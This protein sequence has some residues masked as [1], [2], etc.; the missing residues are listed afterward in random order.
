MPGYQPRVTTD[1]VWFNGTDVHTFSLSTGLGVRITE[2][3]GWD[4]RPDVRDVRELRFGQDGERADNLYLGGRTI[5]IS[6]QVYGSSWVDLQ[7]RKRALAAV[8][9]PSSTEVLFKVPDPATASPTG[10]YA[11]TGMTGYERVSARV[12]EPIAFGDMLGS[13][14]MTFQVSLRASDPRVYSDVETSTDS[15]TTGTA[16]R[17]VTV[18]QAGTYATPAT[19]TATGPTA[20]TATVSEPSGPLSLAW[21]GLTLA[22]GESMSFD[23]LERTATFNATFQ[24]VRLA[25]TDIAAQWMLNETS[26]T[27]ADNGEGTAAYDGTYTGGFTLN[28]AGPA[29]G[30]ASTTFNGST[31]YVTVPYNAALHP[32]ATAFECWAKT[33]AATTQ[34]ILDNDNGTA[35]WYLEFNSAGTIRFVVRTVAGTALTISS[36]VLPSS[37]WYHIVAVIDK[38]NNY[39]SLYVNGALVQRR[40]VTIDETAVTSGALQIARRDTSE[41]LTGSV[42]ACTMYETALSSS[43]VSDLYSASSATTALSG[44]GYLDAASLQWQNL[45]TASSTFTLASTGL[46]T[47]S[48]LNVTYR[49]ARL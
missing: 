34:C 37:T 28:Q 15:G 12:I 13:V 8:F 33:T 41:Y 48:K 43:Q 49:D 27:T 31:G 32:N 44:Y 23:T 26:G 20:A 25:R 39:F 22:A 10:T 18:D 36:A 21:S 6:G 24:R 40:D 35:G 38:I 11:T 19:I 4:E 3:R 30:I 45:G 46:D 1:H 14:G 29:A 2:I 47:G 42:A 17:T 5:T 16:S 7:A 9:Q